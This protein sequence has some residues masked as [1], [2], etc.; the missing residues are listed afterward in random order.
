MGCYRLAYETH[1]FHG[2]ERTWVKFLYYPN[3]GVD[4][5]AFDNCENSLNGSFCTF[6]SDNSD[7]IP[8]RSQIRDEFIGLLVSYNAN[9]HFTDRNLILDDYSDIV[10]GG[11]AC[12]IGNKTQRTVQSLEDLTQHHEPDQHLEEGANS[13][14]MR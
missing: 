2:I 7:A 6:C 3:N 14:V 13:G 8:C 12:R 4:V 10:A 1:I 5:F 9:N 11:I